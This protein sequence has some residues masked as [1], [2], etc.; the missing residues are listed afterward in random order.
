MKFVLHG[1]TRIIRKAARTRATQKKEVRAYTPVLQR[2]I[3]Q[4]VW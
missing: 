1:L 4:I 2:V 3:E